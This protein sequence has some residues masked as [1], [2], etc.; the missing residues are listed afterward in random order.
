MIVSSDSLVVLIHIV[1][2]VWQSNDEEESVIF[3][4]SGSYFFIYLYMHNVYNIVR[5]VLSFQIITGFF[6]SD[7]IHI[8][9]WCGFFQIQ[10]DDGAGTQCSFG[11]LCRRRLRLRR[12]P[13]LAL[14]VN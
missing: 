2:S 4:R 8:L 5:V 6:V 11:Q 14:L 12:R 1:V 3:F 10:D 13:R 9:A 7:S